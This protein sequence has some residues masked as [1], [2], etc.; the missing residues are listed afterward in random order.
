MIYF[1]KDQTGV[2]MP[3][4]E[5]IPSRRHNGG[6]TACSDVLSMGRWVFYDGK[7]QEWMLWALLHRN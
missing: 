4:L 2:V 6:S 3:L 5:L 7:Q 1:E